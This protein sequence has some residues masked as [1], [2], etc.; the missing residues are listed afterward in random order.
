MTIEGP[1][2]PALPP[3]QQQRFFFNAML[4]FTSRLAKASPLVYLLD[5]LQWAD[6][7]STLLLEHVAPHLSRMP[8]LMVITYRDV[9]A[10]IGEP[11]KRA[12]ALHP[13][14]RS[15]WRNLR[16]LDTLR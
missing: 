1:N 16:Y 12:L 15:A 6:E 4:E 9:A 5:D 11:F 7:S 10:D 2:T 13:R 8:V 14:Y 3:E